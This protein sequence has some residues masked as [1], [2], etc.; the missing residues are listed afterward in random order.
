MP[1]PHWHMRVRIVRD[2]PSRVEEFDTSRFRVGVIYDVNAPL[3]DLLVLNGYAEPADDSPASHDTAVEASGS[4][5][6]DLPSSRKP[7]RQE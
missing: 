6:R 7:P 1:R 4:I 2:V 5:E 3:C